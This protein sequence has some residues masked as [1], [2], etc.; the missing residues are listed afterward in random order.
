MSK[1]PMFY[2]PVCSPIDW[3]CSVWPSGERF[4]WDRQMAVCEANG[5]RVKDR[6][7]GVS[8]SGHKFWKWKCLKTG[9]ECNSGTC[10]D[11]LPLRHVDPPT[12]RHLLRRGERF[13]GEG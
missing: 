1:R 10:H 5:E 4:D 8:P 11:A 3:G 12:P 9:K 7:D 13:L 2:G 6:L